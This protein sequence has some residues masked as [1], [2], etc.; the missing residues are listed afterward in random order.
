MDIQDRRAVI[1][2]DR[3]GSMFH[4]DPLG[5]SRLERAKLMAH[6]EID[7]LLGFYDQ[8]YPGVNRIAIMSFNSDGIVIEQDFTIDYYDL[9]EAVDQI[10]NPRH[11]TPL[12]AAMCQ[13]HCMLTD[14]DATA[15]YVLT[16]TDGLENESQYFDICNICDP[17]NYLM[18][19][20]WNY[21][22]DLSNPSSC[23][24]WQLCLAEQFAQTGTNI[25]HYFGEPINPFDKGSPGLEDMYFLM[26]TAE[27]SSG[28]FFYHSDQVANGYLC[29]DANRDFSV[30]TSDAV[31][32]INYIFVG[33]DPPDPL[34]SGD[35][36]CDGS[37]NVS[38]AVHIINYVFIG[39]N[40]PCDLNGDGIPDC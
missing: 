8:A 16:F 17:C 19:T 25:V 11:D 12:A 40:S 13:A 6:D 26:S 3:S 18:E 14:F 9:H 20:G 22:C 37:V 35:V 10:A 15:E 24:D 33:G 32:I 5:Q 36:N 34:E 23:T 28:E 30:N 29:G 31:T 27:E 38:D 21:D 1:A 7:Q 4:T 2:I 39:G